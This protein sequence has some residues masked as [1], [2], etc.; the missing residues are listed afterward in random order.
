MLAE[1][2]YYA[3]VPF[4]IIFGFRS[5][6][7]AARFATRASERGWRAGRDSQEARHLHIAREAPVK[8]GVTKQLIDQIDCRIDLIV[9]C[10][11]AQTIP[12]Y[13]GIHTKLL[14]DLPGVVETD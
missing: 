10:K 12:S 3:G 5:D 9:I 7:S 14:S 1:L 8:S 4:E 2:L 6:G 11:T 13:A